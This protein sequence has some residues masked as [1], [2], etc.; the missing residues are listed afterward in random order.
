MYAAISRVYIFEKF[1]ETSLSIWY[2][3]NLPSFISF[4]DRW[5]ECFYMKFHAM[6]LTMSNIIVQYSSNASASLVKVL[7][8]NN[9]PWGLVEQV[10]F[11]C[12]PQPNNHKANLNSINKMRPRK[13]VFHSFL[14]VLKGWRYTNQIMV[15]PWCFK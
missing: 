12:W 7:V 9:G 3:I 10:F 11:W 15:F 5:L 4:F 1:F 6:W 14:T 2:H 13:E 8:S